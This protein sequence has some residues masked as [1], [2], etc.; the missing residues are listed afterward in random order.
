MVLSSIMLAGKRREDVL[1]HEPS[2]GSS[3]SLVLRQET[4]ISTKTHN[5]LHK[6]IHSIVQVLVVAFPTQSKHCYLL[7]FPVLLHGLDKENEFIISHFANTIFAIFLAFLFS[8]NFLDLEVRPELIEANRP[9]GCDL[10]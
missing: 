2:V 6:G 4:N 9:I 8:F 1:P 3:L 5:H 10:S 7:C